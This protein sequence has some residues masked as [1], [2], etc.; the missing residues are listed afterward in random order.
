M[1]RKI[2]KECTKYLCLTLAVAALVLVLGWSLK[3]LAQYK[4]RQANDVKNCQTNQQ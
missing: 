3:E 1:N 4:N 2:I